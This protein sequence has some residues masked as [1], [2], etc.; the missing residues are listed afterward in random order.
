MQVGSESDGDGRGE[1]PLGALR[2]APEP[3][4]LATARALKVDPAS[5][6]TGCAVFYPPPSCPAC[7]RWTRVGARVCKDDQ[8][9]KYVP[10]G[11]NVEATRRQH[12][13]A[14]GTFGLRA[15]NAFPIPSLS[16]PY[17]VLAFRT[18]PT[19]HAHVCGRLELPL[20]WQ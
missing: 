8:L 2:L 5:N 1:G 10:R 3:C 12:P 19:I 20:Q 9:P 7:L 4:T 13:M 17:L 14:R 18:G 15:L 11:A 6:R 16:S